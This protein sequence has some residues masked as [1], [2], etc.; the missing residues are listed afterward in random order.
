ML[1]LDLVR[2]WIDE[3]KSLGVY[4]P[5]AAVV[6][7][8][9][10][11]GPSSRVVLIRRITDEGLIFFTNLTSKKAK[12]IKANS[13]V[14]LNFYF[15][16]LYKQINIRGVAQLIPDNVADSYFAQRDRAKQISAWASKQSQLMK[17]EDELEQAIAEYEL[18]FQNIAVERPP[19]WSGYIIIPEY[20][21]FWQEGE[22]RR[23]KR[24]CWQRSASGQ[25]DNFQ[26]Y[27]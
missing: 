25:W 22:A 18:K 12:D 3:Y 5:E 23:H 11:S 16:Q 6:S 7:T 14:A 20:F 19:F 1:P 17:S 8:M 13:K 21:E 26:L 24:S 10:I 9:S 2:L 4:E 15:R 27:P